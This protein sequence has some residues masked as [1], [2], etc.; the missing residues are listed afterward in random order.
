MHLILNLQASQNVDGSVSEILNKVSKKATKSTLHQ[1]HYD[2]YSRML[3]LVTLTLLLYFTSSLTQSMLQFSSLQHAETPLACG[4]RFLPHCRTYCKSGPVHNHRFIPFLAFYL[5]LFPCFNYIA[6]FY[7]A[8]SCSAFFA[9][10]PPD[11][12][13]TNRSLQPTKYFSAPPPPPNKALMVLLYYN[14]GRFV[15][16][17]S[18]DISTATLCP[19]VLCTA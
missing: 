10:F 13:H 9:C 3:S 6:Q 4:G 5:P 19:I 17:K 2:L 18:S 7:F 8:I 15:Q 16:K 11:E 1:L 12:T 14:R